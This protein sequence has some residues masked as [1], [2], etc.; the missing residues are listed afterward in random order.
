MDRN[1]VKKIAARLNNPVLLRAFE[2]MS[3]DQI[4]WEDALNEAAVELAKQND[5][6]LNKLIA[7][8]A[9]PANRPPAQPRAERPVAGTPP[10]RKLA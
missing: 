6:F 5:Y 3:V 10:S 7:Q 9:Q 1:E 2:R 8:Q 4:S